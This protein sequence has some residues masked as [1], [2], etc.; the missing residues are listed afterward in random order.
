MLKLWQFTDTHLFVREAMPQAAPHDDQKTLLESGAILDHALQEFLEEPDCGILLISGD[1]TCNGHADEHRALIEKLRRIARAGKRVLVITATHDYGIGKVDEQNTSGLPPLAR[2]DGRVFRHELRGLYEE[3]GLRDAVA[4]YADGLSYVA[5]LEEGCRL[6]C[7][8]DDGNG[9]SF[10]GFDAAQMQ[11]IL[12]QLA[13]AK[14]DGQ[15]IFGMAHHPS[16]P[17]SPIYPLI[18]ERDMMGGWKENTRILADAGLRCL[19]TGHTHMHNIAKR[20]T[21]AGNPYWDI[22]T[23]CLVGYPGVF[24][25]AELDGDLLRVKTRALRDFPIDP[26]G[27]LSLR[28]YLKRH[29][30]HLLRDIIE[31]AANDID[32]LAVHAGGFSVE[33]ETIYKLRIPITLAGK[34]ANRITLGGLGRLLCCRG[35]IPESVR[36]LQCKEVFLELVGRIYAGEEIY[37]AQ[38]DMGAALLALAG[39]LQGLLRT[40]IKDLPG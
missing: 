7:L 18:S 3:F 40:E 9:R 36:G 4:V 37:H 28:D 26:E 30:E 16:L 17:P 31:S 12:E 33:R 8:N 15:K 29:F 20:V 22:N 35:R 14:A 24:R 2:A 23:A 11:W 27:K 6:L 38:T 34:F 19:F 1:L 39:R 5:Q 25:T 21:P 32:R 13:R 10:C